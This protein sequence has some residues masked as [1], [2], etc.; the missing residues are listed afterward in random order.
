MGYIT[1]L[2]SGALGGLFLMHNYYNGYIS[3][4]EAV[5]M[6]LVCSLI[7]STLLVRLFP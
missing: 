3:L 2:L 1:S 4:S 6:F 7:V 5:F